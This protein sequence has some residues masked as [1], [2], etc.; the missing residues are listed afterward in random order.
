MEKI[1]SKELDIVLIPKSNFKKK[2]IKLML[3]MNIKENLGVSL[4]IL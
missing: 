3:F 4:W 1:K 2:L